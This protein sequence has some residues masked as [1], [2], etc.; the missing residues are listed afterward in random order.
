MEGVLTFQRRRAV[1]GGCGVNAREGVV[2]EAGGFAEL[3]V[4]EALPLAVEDEF[5]VVDEGDAM[6]LGE[7][8]GAR[9]DEVD[10]G[11][12]FEDE[13]AKRRT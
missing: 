9:S 13:A 6:G 10:V 1:A 8:L 11:A 12:V 3:G 7:L 4:G 5:R 2:A